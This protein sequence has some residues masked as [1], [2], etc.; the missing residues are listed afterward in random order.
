MS[1][2]ELRAVDAAFG[3]SG[4]IRTATSVILD[5]RHYG[6]GTFEIHVPDKWAAPLLRAGRM[7]VIN[8]DPDRSGVVRGYKW[9]SASG[10]APEGWT[11]TGYTLPGLLK[12]RITVPPGDAESLGWDKVIGPAETAIKHYIRRNLTAPGN[13]SRTMAQ[14]LLAD[15]VGRGAGVAWR[16]RYEPLDEVVQAIGEYADMGIRARL[17]LANRRIV[18]DVEPGTDRTTQQ[19]G[20]SPVVFDPRFSNIRSASYTY[21]VDGY[22]NTGYAGGAG[23]DENRLVYILGNE[24]AGMDRFETFID[25]SGAEDI[26]DLKYYG[27]NRLAEKKE[28]ETIEGSVLTDRAFLFG[29]DYDLGDKVT[30]RPKAGLELHTRITG[31]KEVWEDTG[32][33]CEPLF[34]TGVISMSDVLKRMKAPVK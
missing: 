18:V 2:C 22:S 5:R 17:D 8:G 14:V 9:E 4:V 32:Y 25:C 15:D 6:P 28:T 24:N 1:L 23:E 27:G 31:V 20:R 34:G 16:S 21:S 12:Q 3:L 33:T 29:R 13:A 19:D 11:I 26:D 7:I 30:V 10:N